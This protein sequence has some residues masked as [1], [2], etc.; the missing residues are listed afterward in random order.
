M[1]ALWPR[2]TFYPMN[3]VREGR[4]DCGVSSERSGWAGGAGMC[5]RW[6]ELNTM[7]MFVSNVTFSFVVPVQRMSRWLL[8]GAGDVKKPA[9]GGLWAMTT[10]TFADIVGVRP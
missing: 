10:T 9:R 7:F 2:D 6:N 4:P 8:G 5:L 1:A 3:C